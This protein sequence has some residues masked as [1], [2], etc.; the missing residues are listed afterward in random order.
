MDNNKL[1]ALKAEASERG[2]KQAWKYFHDALYQPHLLSEQVRADIE[3]ACEES[4]AEPEEPRRH[5][6]RHR[7]EEQ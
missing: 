5:R 7:T 6:G 4:R 2:D 1:R 3:R